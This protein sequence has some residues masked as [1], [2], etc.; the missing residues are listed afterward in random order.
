MKEINFAEQPKVKHFRML[1]DYAEK[2]GIMLIITTNLTWKELT[3]KYGERTTD[4]LK[5]LVTPIGFKGK[6]LR[7]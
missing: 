4:R 6:S 7:K 1:V 5:A 2:N 3:E